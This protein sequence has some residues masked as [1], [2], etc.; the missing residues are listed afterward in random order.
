MGKVES[1]FGGSDEGTLLVNV[2][3]ERFSE[4]KVENVRSGVVI[5]DGPSSE[6]YVS[7]LYADLLMTAHLVIRRDHFISDIQLAFLQLTD[8]KNVTVVDLHI[9]DLE[10][11][12][13]VNSKHTRI[14]LLSTLLGVE[15]C[16]VEQDSERLVGGDVLC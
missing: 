6:L 11:G 9:G 13:S 1:E 16:L 3:A 12:L 4:G 5:S 7:A 2:V 15:V 8:M 10:L 14:V